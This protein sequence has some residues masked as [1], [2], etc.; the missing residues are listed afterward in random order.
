MK[1]E[2]ENKRIVDKIL[3]I[4]RQ[5]NC[6]PKTVRYIFKLV[7]EN[8][9]YQIP[10]QTKSLPD[11]LNPS[12]VDY[13]IELAYK[14]SVFDGI[15]IK[16]LIHTGLRINEC[17]NILIQHIDF[18]NDVLKVVMGKG[19]KDRFVPLSRNIKQ[20]LLTY[21]NGRTKGFV[22][23]KYNETEYTKRALQYRVENIIKKC[24]FSKQ[25]I[26]T[27][28]LRHTFAC[29][30]LANGLALDRIQLLMGH[31]KITTTQIYAKLELG[32]LKSDFI[33]LIGN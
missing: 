27:H 19:N 1:Q 5:Y 2:I 7:R 6:T 12:E 26:T 4:L 28:S 25:N 11:F 31:E 13:I 15:L 8:G 32:Q 18:N 24:N 10:K 22:F 16:F 3:E 23:C 17:K 20:S 14:E 33:R 29:M 30:C 9:K 21:L